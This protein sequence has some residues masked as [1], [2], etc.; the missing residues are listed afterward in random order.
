MSQLVELDA[1]R[2]VAL[3]KLDNPEHTRYLITEHPDTTLML[4]PPPLR[5]KR[6]KHR[7]RKKTTWP[8]NSASGCPFGSAWP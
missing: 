2:R 4:T 8:L 7:P 3:G 1:R 5:T 6:P